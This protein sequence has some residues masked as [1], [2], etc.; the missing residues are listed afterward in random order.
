[1]S[2]LEAEK[3]GRGLP[4]SKTQARHGR[5][6]REPK[7]LDCGSPP[8]L[9]CRSTQNDRQHTRRHVHH[10]AAWHPLPCLKKCEKPLKLAKTVL[11]RGF[12]DL[13]V[14]TRPLAGL[15]GGKTRRTRICAERHL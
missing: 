13:G 7:V 5:E 10:K 4:Q 14:A 11:K 15:S 8:P 9:F 1:V 3:S 12:P 6:P 2:G